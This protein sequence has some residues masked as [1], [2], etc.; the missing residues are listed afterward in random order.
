L[1][2]DFKLCPYCGESITL[3]EKMIMVK[4]YKK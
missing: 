1:R 4:D 3:Q 2:P